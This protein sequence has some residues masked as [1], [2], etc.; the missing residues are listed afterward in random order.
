MIRCIT[1]LIFIIVVLTA[2]FMLAKW[3]SAQPVTPPQNVQKQLDEIST[4]ITPKLVFVTS[5][6]Y[7]G[8]LGGL[9][10][11]DAKCQEAADNAGLE[12]TF[13]AWLSDNSDSPSTRFTTLSLGPYITTRPGSGTI[14]GSWS[15]LTDREIRDF[16]NSNEN[17][18]SII[19][20]TEV[21]TGTGSNG[22]RG[23]LDPTCDGWTSGDATELGVVGTTNE[24]DD[25]WTFH[26]IRSCDNTFPI[27]CFQVQ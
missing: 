25:S 26:N 8:N 5:T 23:V 7:D 20:S 6:P 17:G 22:G 14:A 2:V 16:I 11:A 13:M 3:S 24:L 1:P 19:G 12:G 9:A 27:Y 21:W 10:G 18:V 4:I 15:D